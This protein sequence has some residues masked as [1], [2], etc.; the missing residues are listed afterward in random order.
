[1]FLIVQNLSCISCWGNKDN[2]GYN[3]IAVYADFPALRPKVKSHSIDDSS[4]RLIVDPD[5]KDEIYHYIAQKSILKWV[6]LQSLVAK[7]CKIRK[8][9]CIRTAYCLLAVI[10]YLITLHSII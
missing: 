8:C 7:C 4:N 1:M 10:S 6:Q 2:F 5:K 9:A 3:N